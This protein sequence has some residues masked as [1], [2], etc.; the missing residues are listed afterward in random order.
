M[1][2]GINYKKISTIVSVATVTV[3][4]LLRVFKALKAI[5]EIAAMPVINTLTLKEKVSRIYL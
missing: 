4:K 3:L 2:S 5:R 1:I